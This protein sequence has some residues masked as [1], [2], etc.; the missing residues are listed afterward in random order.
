[1]SWAWYQ[2]RY[3]AQSPLHIG[4]H[5]LGMVQRTRPYVT[6]RALWGAITSRLAQFLAGSGQPDYETVGCEV[7]QGLHFTY[8]FPSLGPE[9]K[10]LIPWFRMNDDKSCEL[11]YGAGGADGEQECLIP[12]LQFE[13]MFICTRG[14]TAVG[15]QSQTALDGSL[16][17]TEFLAHRVRGAQGTSIPVF[18]L[19]YLGIDP[20]FPHKDVLWNA[21]TDLAVGGER[22]YGYGRL[23]LSRPEQPMQLEDN[24]KLFGLGTLVRDGTSVIWPPGAPF[25]AHVEVC[26]TL[27]VAG[28]I[29]PFLGRETENQGFGKRISTMKPCWVPGSVLSSSA[30]CAFSIG[31]Y[32]IWHK[33]EIEGGR[34]AVGTFTYQLE[35][36]KTSA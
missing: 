19:G 36:K 4:Y 26:G 15:P 6:G 29:E 21:M 30:S 33:L 20:A 28:D 13:R 10:P 35:P 3:T 8:L 32:G 16:H 23:R 11:Y 31:D 34:C 25:P 24:E 5:T 12:S 18:F 14:Q 17:E 9:G 22:S 2:L 1:M 27:P 7:R